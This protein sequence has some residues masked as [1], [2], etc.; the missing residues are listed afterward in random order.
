MP[1]LLE[2]YI[3]KAATRVAIA[4][5]AGRGDSEKV[6]TE[7]A[8][9]LRRTLGTL[10]S[11]APSGT[12]IITARPVEPVV[13]EVRETPSADT[14]SAPPLETLFPLP[15]ATPPRRRRAQKPVRRGRVVAKQAEE[16]LGLR[17]QEPL[18]VA[19][20]EQ[21]R[22]E[23]ERET[24][25]PE[26]GLEAKAPPP[27]EVETPSQPEAEAPS[28]QEPEKAELPVTEQQD[29]LLEQVSPELEQPEAETELRPTTIVPIE[30]TVTP[31]YIVCLEDGEHV[32]NLR[33]HLKRVYRMSPAEYRAKWRLPDQYPMAAPSFMRVGPRLGDL[34]K[35]FQPGKGGSQRTERKAS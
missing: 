19:E 34:S 32:K 28:T 27:A 31:H 1:T 4:A 6:T 18:P 13:Q 10:L 15:K 3:D 24:E 14:L 22:V 20:P 12:P 29:A 2:A 11:P 7:L 21:P 9:D 16:D 30:Q 35:L 25:V 23:P 33:Q 5:T 8:Q 17:Q 26:A